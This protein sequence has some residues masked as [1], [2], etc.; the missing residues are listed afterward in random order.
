MYRIQYLLASYMFPPIQ[1]SR[2]VSLGLISHQHRKIKWRKKRKTQSLKKSQHGKIE[3]AA[4]AVCIGGFVA[5]HMP[6]L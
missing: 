3:N 1:Y 2:P 4:G 6:T 5:S